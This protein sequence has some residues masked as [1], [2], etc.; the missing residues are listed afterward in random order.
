MQRYRVWLLALVVS[1]FVPL[2]AA[3]AGAWEFK[4][5]GNYTNDYMYLTQTG[6]KGFFGHYDIDNSAG[7]SSERNR[8]L[9]EFLGR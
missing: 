6:P 3:P 7:A 8:K 1:L 4:M 5:T 9:P 2:V